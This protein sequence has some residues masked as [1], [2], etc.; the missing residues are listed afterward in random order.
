[1]L[2]ERDDA[3]PSVK[4]APAELERGLDTRE[5][6]GTS[7]RDVMTPVVHAVLDRSSIAAAAALMWRERV[8]H[9][10]VVDERGGVCGMVSTLDVARWV[11]AQ[12]RFAPRETP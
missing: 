9:V 5:L 2:R 4:L 1:V 6:G 12:G 7:A 3:S 8:H 10:V 11:A